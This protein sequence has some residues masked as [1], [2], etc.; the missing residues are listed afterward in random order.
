MDRARYSFLAHAGLELWHPGDVGALHDMLRRVSLSRGARVLDVGAG[1]AAVSLH[2]ARTYGARCVAVERSDHAHA[3][4][5]REIEASGQAERITLLHGDF[6]TFPLAE[7]SFALAI[8]LGASHAIGDYEKA[9]KRIGELVTRP[10]H[11]LMG[12]LYWRK[13]P[14]DE[15]LAFLGM[16][17][18]DL[19]THAGNIEIARTLGFETVATREASSTELDAYEDRYAAN[20]EAHVAQH[21]DDPDA[22]AMLETIHAWRR[23]YLQWGRG[24]LGFAVYLFQLAAALVR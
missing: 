8:C 2:L 1:R 17:L 12:E 21:P 16:K 4:A 18:E 13:P 7:R 3:L 9:L 22:G 23:A 24:T 14:S 20:I 5:A 10:G 6:G 11:V 19:Q 15:Y